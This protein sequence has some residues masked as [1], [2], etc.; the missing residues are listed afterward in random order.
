M[1]SNPD[2]RG[3]K[4]HKTLSQDSQNSDSGLNR[5]P[6]EYK[7]S[8]TATMNDPVCIISLAMVV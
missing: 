8:F 5:E 3:K 2:L 7:K 6:P 4:N 1:G